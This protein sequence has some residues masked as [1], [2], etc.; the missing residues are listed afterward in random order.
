MREG[1]REQASERERGHRCVCARERDMEEN[2]QR[3][4]VSMGETERESKAERMRAR[5]KRSTYC[6]T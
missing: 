5:N 2:G 6:V 1:G 3:A 4:R